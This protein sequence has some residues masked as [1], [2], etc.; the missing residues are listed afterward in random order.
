M[1]SLLLS[2]CS[3]TER[4]KDNSQSVA[5]QMHSQICGEKGSLT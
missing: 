2:D 3:E 1:L 4:F 5:G